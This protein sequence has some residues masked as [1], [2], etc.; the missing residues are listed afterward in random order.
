MR[1][2]CSVLKVSG[3]PL[4][5]LPEMNHAQIFHHDSL[6]RVAP[7]SQQQVTQLV[8]DD[9]AQNHGF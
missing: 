6:I 3:A 2:A 1:W 9:K 5:G 8:R 7:L 4:F